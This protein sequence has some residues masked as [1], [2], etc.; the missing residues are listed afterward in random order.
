MWGFFIIF[1]VYYLLLIIMDDDFEDF[2]DF[3]DK[4]NYTE[5]TFSEE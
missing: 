2:V 4:N 5:P 1:T 3:Y